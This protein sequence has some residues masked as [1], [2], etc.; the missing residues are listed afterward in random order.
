MSVGVHPII[1]LHVSIAA[2][3]TLHRKCA[4]HQLIQWANLA[5]AG[6]PAF[7]TDLTDQRKKGF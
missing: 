2:N 7:S 5:E 3:E 6:P 1:R 4:W